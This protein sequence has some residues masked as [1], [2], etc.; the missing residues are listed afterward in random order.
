MT[1]LGDEIR[2]A[3]ARS[4]LHAL[5]AQNLASPRGLCNCSARVEQAVIF[6]TLDYAHGVEHANKD[7][8]WA[9]PW[10][11]NGEAI[12]MTNKVGWCSGVQRCERFPDCPCGLSPRSLPRAWPG[13]FQTIGTRLGAH[14]DRA[15]HR[16][17]PIA[18]AV[19]GHRWKR[20][21]SQR[22]EPKRF[23]TRC[24]ADDCG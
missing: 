1:A 9:A 14:V 4:E 2:A 23:C 20:Y 18:C 15:L 12:V 11:P 6:C 13:R 7:H 3:T 19:L 17:A 8:R 10:P 24:L 16:A 22:W 5:V 21:T